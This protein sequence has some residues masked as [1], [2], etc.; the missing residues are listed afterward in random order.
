M[1]RLHRLTLFLICA[2]CAPAAAQVPATV[3]QEK[4]TR[5]TYHK[6]ELY[7]AAAQVFQN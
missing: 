5:E 1:T 6:L 2:C 3:A 4:L 7:N